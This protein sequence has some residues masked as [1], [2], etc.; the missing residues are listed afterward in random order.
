MCFIFERAWERAMSICRPAQHNNSAH[1]LRHQPLTRKSDMLGNL[2]ASLY[3]IVI[4]YNTFR[5]CFS[6]TRRLLV[7]VC[8]S[9][10]RPQ[11]RISQYRNTCIRKE[12]SHATGPAERNKPNVESELF[13]RECFVME[14]KPVGWNPIGNDGGWIALAWNVSKKILTGIP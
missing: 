2:L 3:F 5:P 11:S 12:E 6:R 14:W 8:H 4:R 10:E 1:R 7:A 9:G 13:V